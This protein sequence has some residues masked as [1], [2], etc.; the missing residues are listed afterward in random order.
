MTPL[1][2]VDGVVAEFKELWKMLGISYTSFVRSSSPEHQKT[3]QTLL[4]KVFDQGDV[5]KKDY[6]GL[7]CVPC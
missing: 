3:V 7:Y 1:Q 4:Q 2:Y 5:Y 6:E